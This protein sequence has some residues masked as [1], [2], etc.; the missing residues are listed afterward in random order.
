MIKL[1]VAMDFTDV[2]RLAC[3]FA[4]Q[5]ALGLEAGEIYFLHVLTQDSASQAAAPLPAIENAIA[6]MRDLAE[7]ELVTADGAR[8]T[9]A[10]ELCYRAVFGR[11]E[12]EI[13]R[14]ARE[15]AVDGIVI[16]TNSRTGV[17]RLLLG[18]VA[19]KVVRGAGC[20]VMV[21]KNKHS[22]PSAP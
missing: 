17:E 12:A 8:L 1:L 4:G 9:G 16:G 10:I 14:I 15:H 18:S 5:Y 7:K 22:P 19:E 2:S 6:R 21:V 13:L 11:P 20:T 3:R